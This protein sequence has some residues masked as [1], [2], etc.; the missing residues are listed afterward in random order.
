MH[1]R[2]EVVESAL[3][4]TAWLAPQQRLYLPR[5]QPLFPSTSYPRTFAAIRFRRPRPLTIFITVSQFS[6]SNIAGRS[7][8]RWSWQRQTHDTCV[9]KPSTIPTTESATFKHIRWSLSTLALHALTGS[10]P[11]IY[12]L[13]RWNI[14]NLFTTVT[15]LNIRGVNCCTGTS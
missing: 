13:L 11:F 4:A 12:Q 7:S 8:Y 9:P 15:M 2:Y 14:K 6:T 1:A 5:Y 3:G 10:E